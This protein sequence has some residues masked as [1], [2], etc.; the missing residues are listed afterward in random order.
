MF[1]IVGIRSIKTR[2]RNG[3]TLRRHCGKC[4]FL[5]DLEEHVL[6][7][8]VTLFFI[9]VIP[10][11]KG[12][13]LLICNR[14]A[15]SFYPQ[16]EDYLEAARQSHHPSNDEKAIITCVAC[17]GRLRIPVRMDRELLVTCP[18]CKEQFSVNTSDH[19]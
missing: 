12:E 19:K 14:C 17:N 16:A 1:F 7:R 10:I 8:Y 5:S 2:P 3:L 15:A 11:S 9:P 18:H 13:S 4:H 6:R